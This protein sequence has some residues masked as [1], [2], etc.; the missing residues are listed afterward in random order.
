MKMVDLVILVVGF[1]VVVLSAAA[2][3]VCMVLG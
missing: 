1:W 3:V 2:L